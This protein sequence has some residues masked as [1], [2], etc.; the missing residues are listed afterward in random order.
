MLV[1]PTSLQTIDE[2]DSF[3]FHIPKPVS[4][5]HCTRAN[6]LGVVQVLLDARRETLRQTDVENL[7]LKSCQNVASRQGGDM[8]CRR[9]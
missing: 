1:Q 8:L 2:V 9:G 3:A 6:F 4:T 7:I 5:P